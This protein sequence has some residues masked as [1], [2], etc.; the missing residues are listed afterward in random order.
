MYLIERC[1]HCSPVYGTAFAVNRAYHACRANRY[2]CDLVKTISRCMRS[3]LCE[4]RA[5]TSRRVCDDH[6]DCY[7]HQ[8][9]EQKTLT[10]TSGIIKRG[11]H[12]QLRGWSI[13]IGVHKCLWTAAVSGAAMERCWNNVKKK[14]Q[15]ER[16]TN[17]KGRSTSALTLSEM[18]FCLL[19]LHWR[20]VSGCWLLTVNENDKRY[21]RMPVPV[22]STAV[23][24]KV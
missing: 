24:D 9:I 17:P 12:L 7:C 16:D 23:R 2:V 21:I 5:Y 20:G 22:W 10:L 1:K 3:K 19:M 11:L 15:R 18:G 14:R 6:H 4:G 8:L 13:V